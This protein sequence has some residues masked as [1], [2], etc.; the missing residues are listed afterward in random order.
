MTSNNAT[1]R[2]FCVKCS[3]NTPKYDAH[4]AKTYKKRGCGCR[5]KKR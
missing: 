2:W 1:N 4:V 3:E 5:G